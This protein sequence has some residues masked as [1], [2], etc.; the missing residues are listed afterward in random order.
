MDAFTNLYTVVSGEKMNKL[1]GSEFKSY[2]K[3]MKN[4]RKKGI[5]LYYPCDMET[6]PRKI[7]EEISYGSGDTFMRDVFFDKEGRLRGIG[8]TRIDKNKKC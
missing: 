8:F 6:S 3:E 1:Y 7:A 4:L 2:F 5:H